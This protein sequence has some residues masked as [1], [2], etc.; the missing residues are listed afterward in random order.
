MLF[1]KSQVILRNNY[2]HLSQLRVD[3][4]IYKNYLLFNMCINYNN[5]CI[6]NVSVI[7]SCNSLD[8]NADNVV[9]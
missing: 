9:N 2:L 3:F 4:S 1:T 7:S 5:C 6:V 8:V